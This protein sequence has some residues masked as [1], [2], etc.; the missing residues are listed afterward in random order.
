VIEKR[1]ADCDKNEKVVIK[2]KDATYLT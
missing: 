2:K 1:H